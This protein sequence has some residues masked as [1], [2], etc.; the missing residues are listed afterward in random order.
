MIFCNHFLDRNSG[1][2]KEP[3]TCLLKL[4]KVDKHKFYSQS[5]FHLEY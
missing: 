5:S 1:Y 4:R 2:Q 3:A